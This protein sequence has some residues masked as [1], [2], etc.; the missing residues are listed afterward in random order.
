[1]LLVFGLAVQC[2]KS[3]ATSSED[4]AL[5]KLGNQTVEEAMRQHRAFDPWSVKP[6]HTLLKS[7]CQICNCGNRNRA[8]DGG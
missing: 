2:R 6:G 5:A 3:M 4:I 8:S 1:M 7:P